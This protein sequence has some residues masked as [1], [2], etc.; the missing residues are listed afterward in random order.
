MCGSPAG[1]TDKSLDPDF[2]DSQNHSNVLEVDA[3]SVANPVVQFT[4]PEHRLYEKKL[5]LFTLH[6]LLQHMRFFR[7]GA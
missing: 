3:T 1:R 4:L 5:P 2:F 7:T 6:F